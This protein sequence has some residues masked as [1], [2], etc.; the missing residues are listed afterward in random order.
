MASS[1][2]IGTDAFAC[3]AFDL[4]GTIYFGDTIAEGALELVTWLEQAGAVVVFFTNNS[5]K[6]RRAVVEKLVRMGLPASDENT[7]T[8]GAAAGGY[9]ND[10]GIRRV[11]LIGTPGLAEELAAEGIEVTPDAGEAEA[12]VVGLVPGFDFAVAPEIL[13]SL[14]GDVPIIAANMDMTYPVEGG[15]S[16]PGCGAIVRAVEA[17]TGRSAE[18][19]VGKPGTFMLDLLC[20][21]HGL[22]RTDVLVVGDNADSDIAMALKAGCRS[23][24]IDSA[25]AADG[26]GATVV[27]RGLRELLT[28][29]SG[30]DAA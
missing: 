28:L 23:V 16:R 14:P 15:E 29:L 19:V 22:E 25:G 5:V 11:A 1:V 8:S 30:T 21:E 13:G 4:D 2:R 26:A 7:Y 12:L 20:R 27:V 6:T 10:R 24:L 17:W 18:A 3:V 9:L